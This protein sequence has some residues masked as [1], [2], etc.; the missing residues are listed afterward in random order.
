MCAIQYGYR[1]LCM[2]PDSV[3]AAECPPIKPP[4]HE[5]EHR[6]NDERD[7]RAGH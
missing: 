3:P 1:P 5:K 6:Q 4:A 7:K 2:C